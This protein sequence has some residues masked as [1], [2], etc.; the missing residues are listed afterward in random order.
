MLESLFQPIKIGSMVLKNRIVMAPM[1]TGYV[2]PDGTVS[3]RLFDY[4]VEADTV[5]IAVGLEPRRELAE[6]LQGKVHEL[7]AIGDCCQA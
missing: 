5:V 1:G 3:P 2:N 7:H 4:L 6:Q